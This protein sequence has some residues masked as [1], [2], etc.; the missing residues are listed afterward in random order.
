MDDGSKTSF[1]HRPPWGTA[2]STVCLLI[3]GHDV[4]FDMSAGVTA[5]RFSRRSTVQYFK[6]GDEHI[7]VQVEESDEGGRLDLAPMVSLGYFVSCV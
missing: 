5:S 6:E 7:R 1:F 4:L 2:L 3:P